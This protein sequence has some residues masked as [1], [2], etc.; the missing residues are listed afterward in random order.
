[1]GEGKQKRN[2]RKAIVSEAIGRIALLMFSEM[3]EIIFFSFSGG[4]MEVFPL[5]QIIQQ[6]NHDFQ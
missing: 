6:S 1:M 4:P 2:L 3:D 5:S